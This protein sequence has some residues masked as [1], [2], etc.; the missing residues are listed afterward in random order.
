MRLASDDATVNDKGGGSHGDDNGKNNQVLLIAIQKLF[1]GAGTLD[2]FTDRTWSVWAVC[3]HEELACV[4]AAE[5]RQ[6]GTRR[7]INA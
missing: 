2:D 4:S 1:E 3:G 6:G 5:K 7:K